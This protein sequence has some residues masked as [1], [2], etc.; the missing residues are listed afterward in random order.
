MAGSH[1][2][3]AR[4]DLLAL[5]RPRQRLH[6]HRRRHRPRTA[7]TTRRHRR[8]PSAD[9][10]PSRADRRADRHPRRP[11]ATPIGQRPCPNVSI[12][13]WDGKERLNILLIGADERPSDGTYNTDTLIVVSIDPVTKQVAMFSLPRDTVDVPI[14]PGPAR[15]RSG[16]STAARSTPCSPT[17]R[18]RSDLFPG[19][20]RDAR[21]QRAQGDPR[22][23]LRPRHQ[24]LR[25]GQL[26]RLQ[27]GRRR[28]RR[29]DDQ[30]P[31][32]GL[33]RPL[34][35]D[36]RPACDGSTSRAGSST[37]TA[38]RR[39]AT[40]ARATARPTST[41]APP[42]ARP[43]VAAR[44][45]RPA[46]AHPAAP[47]AR[48]RRSRRRSGPTSR[49]TSWRQ[50]L[51]LAAEVDTKNIRSYVFTPPLYQ[52]EYLPARAATSSSR[53][54]SRIRAAVK[55]A[56]TD[57]PG[58]RGAAPDARRGGGRGLGPQRHRR[59]RAAAR[60][61]AG[62]LDYHGARRVGARQKPPGAVPAEHDD[63]RLQRRRGAAARDDRLPRADVRGEGH[64]RGPTR[65]SG[66]TS[67]SRSA[68]DPT[69]ATST[70]PTASGRARARATWRY[71]D[72]RQPVARIRAAGRGRRRSSGRG[73]SRPIG[74][75]SPDPT[76]RWSTSTTGEIWTPVPHRNISSATY[77]SERSIERTSTGMP[78]LLEQLHDRLAGH[79]LEDVVADRRRERDAVADDEQVR[80]RRLVDVAVGGQDERLVEAVELG[81]GLLEGH[82]HVAADDLAAGR[83]RLVG[84]APPGRG[85]DPDARRRCRCSSRTAAR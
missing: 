6:L 14:P 69:L 68:S 65:P 60:D 81:L 31:G 52:K 30:R 17:V 58:R 28:D 22:Q 42:A 32:P 26:R 74:P 45:G 54:S 16:R 39:S 61:L 15:Q 24:V 71:V 62:Y 19:N 85:H 78:S 59:Q 76:G 36:R 51:G 18:N 23:P 77:S 79:A 55:D 34:P 5:G 80:R 7:P 82:V 8:R 33:G 3:V 46:G 12:P 1:V 9:G 56:F 4:Y 35:G 2:V 38:P 64:A 49:S 11:S 13:P 83:Q 57:R 53:T 25:R 40:P 44:A 29:R 63:R 67:S 37:W 43:A 10:H 21:L 27:E 50:L 47:R 75:I 73:R 66:P 48:R 41:A 72:R 20:E 70:A 84:V